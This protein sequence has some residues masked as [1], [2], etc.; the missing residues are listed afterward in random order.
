L[1]NGHGGLNCQISACYEFVRKLFDVLGLS[2]SQKLAKCAVPFQYQCTRWPEVGTNFG[3]L[4]L[5]TRVASIS[6]FGHAGHDIIAI[7]S[8]AG[9]TT[10]GK[11][12]LGKVKRVF[13]KSA[14]L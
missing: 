7:G 3:G 9:G 11:D 14:W 5:L 10:S 12:V 8:S 6:K 4:E 1:S 2:Q 13:H